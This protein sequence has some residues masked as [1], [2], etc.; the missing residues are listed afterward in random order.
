MI[1][2]T[3]INSTRVK[4]RGESSRRIVGNLASREPMKMPLFLARVSESPLGNAA[5]GVRASAIV[6]QIQE[7]A[8]KNLAKN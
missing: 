4:P 2:I 8:R 7:N 6:P 1:T 5:A 3:T